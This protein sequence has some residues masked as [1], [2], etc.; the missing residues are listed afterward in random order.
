M[1][2]MLNGALTIGTDDGANV[3]IR[4]LVGDE[5]FFLFGMT[6]PQVAA[7]QAKGYV[8]SSFYESNDS[9]KRAI[10]LIASGAFTNGSREA[11][12]PVIGDLLSNDRF[13]VLADYQAYID[14]QARVDAAYRDQAAWTRSAI[15]N[16]ARAGFFSSDRAMRDYIDRV[17]KVAPPS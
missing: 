15:L 13:L 14:A 11:A 4:Q 7:L 6:E 17:W 12:G 3:E 1:K 2:F 8:P 10:D 9:L 5:N 16:V